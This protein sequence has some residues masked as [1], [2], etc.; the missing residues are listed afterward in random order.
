MG[1]EL[2]G[3]ALDHAPGAEGLAASHAVERLGLVQRHRL[4]C[5]GAEQQTRREADRILGA[6]FL[7]QSA[8]HAI[9]LDEAQQRRLRRIEERGLGTGADA[10]LAKRAGFLVDRDCAVGRARRQ[11][12]FL[13]LVFGVFEQEIK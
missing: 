1:A 10:G 7:A 6:G 9:T 13:L 2:A 8:L 12:D 4:L 3:H 11:S 5:A